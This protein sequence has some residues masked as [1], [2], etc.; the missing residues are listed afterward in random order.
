PPDEEDL[1]HVALARTL[2][3]LS[4]SQ[5]RESLHGQSSSATLI[6]AAAELREQ[7]EEKEL[8]WSSR[9]M[10]YWTFNPAEHQITHVG[11]Y[12][13][14]EVD[15]LRALVDLYF[16]TTNLYFP[17]L[18]R[19]T[20]ERS[21]AE[22]LHFRDS[23]FGAVVLLVCAIGSRFSDDPRVCGPG[24][25][26]LRCGWKYFDQL[27]HA[28]NHVF[29][30][31]VYHLQY[32]CLAVT[33]LQ[34]STPTACWMLTGIGVRLA[35]DV[36]AHRSKNLR[37]PTVESELWKRAFWVIVC[38]DRLCSAAFGR[39]CGTQYEDFDVELPIECD[40]EFWE[41]VDPAQVFKQPVGKPSQIAYFN[42]FIRLNNILA[43]G[44]KIM[45]SLNK[46]RLMF[47]VR[48]ESWEHIVTELD[49]A[50][51]GWVDSIPS[52]V[53]WDPNRKDD[54]FFDQSAYLY[55]SYYHVQMTIHCPLIPMVR[56]SE[57][58]SLRS[59]AIGTNAARSCSHVSDISRERKKGIPVPVLVNATFKSAS[60]L[61]LNVW[62]GKRTGLAPHMN[63]AIWEVHKCMACIRLCE[64][65]P[66]RRWQST[67]IF[68]DLL[69]ELAAIGQMPLPDRSPAPAP[70]A[71][72]GTKKRP[73]KDDAGAPTR[74]VDTYPTAAAPEI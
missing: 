61:L 42:C 45:Y 2:G 20:F 27:S 24:D 64:Q 44:L 46:A 71:E 26:P 50:L 17:L 70:T 30:H 73:R 11:P 8:P 34:Y 40:D 1:A 41:N 36:G 62:S 35:Q 5:G 33:F 43:F 9:R 72:T 56:K 69:Y 16:I 21:L 65:R 68:G 14:P 12:V 63:S 54:I 66:P 53:R 22:G 18:H 51:N 38:Y 52:H 67:G 58:T 74:H 25:D 59:L 48:D 47:A 4:I 7:Y 19:P 29:A 3:N 60:I 49:S 31:T 28:V 23:S 32:Y 6:R 37:T 10:K 15:L 55:A 57:A 39:P 13:F